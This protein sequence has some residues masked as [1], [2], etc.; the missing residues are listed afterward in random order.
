MEVEVEEKI[1]D[2]H[3][4]DDILNTDHKL[5][6]SFVL[7]FNIPKKPKTKHFVYNFEKA[8]WDALKEVL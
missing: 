8:N 7:D 1:S 5:A 3:G 4:F 6:V 2:I